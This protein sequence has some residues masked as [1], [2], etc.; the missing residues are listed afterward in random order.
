MRQGIHGPIEDAR[1]VMRDHKVGTNEK[2]AMIG[3]SSFAAIFAAAIRR[4]C[5]ATWNHRPYQWAPQPQPPDASGS[6]NRR[7]L[8]IDVP[9]QAL[10]HYSM[11]ALHLAF[12][13]TELCVWL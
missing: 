9:F 11:S 4:D 1:S 12:S 10:H 7:G 6:A 8:S 2:Q 13:L 3:K 5:Q